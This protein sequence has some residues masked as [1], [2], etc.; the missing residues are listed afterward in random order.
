VYAE[1]GRPERLVHDV[2]EGEHQWHGALAL[3][4]L[5]RWLG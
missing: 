3:P 1:L 5:D 2:F 4:F